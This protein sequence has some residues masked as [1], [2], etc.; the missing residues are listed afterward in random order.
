ML[1]AQTVAPDHVGAIETALHLPQAVLAHAVDEAI[2]GGDV[3]F[4]LAGEVV[5]VVVKRDDGALLPLQPACLLQYPR[6]AAGEPGDEGH[7]HQE[8]G[9]DPAPGTAAAFADQGVEAV[10][11]GGCDDDDADGG[12]R[13]GYSVRIPDKC[14]SHAAIQASPI[15]T[16]L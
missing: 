7:D 11:K 9:H 5:G 4:G 16:R 1:D 3:D 15:R 10:E 14:Q 8:G 13:E 6:N 2:E 12:G